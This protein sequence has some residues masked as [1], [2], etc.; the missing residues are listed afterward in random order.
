M[1]TTDIIEKNGFE[2]LISERPPSPE[3]WD[4]AVSEFEG[5]TF[6]Q[7]TFWGDYLNHYKNYNTFYLQIKNGASVI[8]FCL[9]WKEKIT[10]SGFKAFPRIFSYYGPL[11]KTYTKES[12]DAFLGAMDKI[13]KSERVMSLERLTPPIHFDSAPF[14][15]NVANMFFRYSGVYKNSEAATIILDLK[16][17]EE[18]LWNGITYAAKKCLRRNSEDN[19]EV[20][21]ADSKDDLD[22]YCRL[23][24]NFVKSNGGRLPYF[25]PSMLDF[26]KN[27]KKCVEV[28]LAKRGGDVHGGLGILFFNGIIFEIGSCRSDYAIK[29][30]LYV[31]DA[32]KWEVIKWARNNGFR[33][34]DLTGISPSPFTGKD[35]GIR[36]FK[37]KWGGAIVNY[38]NY[39]KVYQRLPYYVCSTLKN[40][41]FKRY[42]Y[43]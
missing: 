35:K 34:Y 40:N 11:L 42:L 27:N 43:R 32:L 24:D 21:I 30:N 9:L 3:K 2:V 6:F 38:R 7:S 5:G 23:L 19:I 31:A 20:V 1:V 18:G 4:K 33:Q 15:E 22:A 17:T 12:M 37:E 13:C 10:F 26:L 39:A 29:N 41:Y 16:K 8:G 25:T 28:F 14:R 36:R